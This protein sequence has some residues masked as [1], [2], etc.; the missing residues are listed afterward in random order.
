MLQERRDLVTPIT[1]QL[2]DVV[3]R[4]IAQPN[5]DHLRRRP[6]ENAHS[7]KVLVLADENQ[8]VILRMLPNRKIGSSEQPHVADMFRPG[9]NIGNCHDEPRRQIFVEKEFENRLSQ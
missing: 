8:S 2:D 5:P 7:V 3:G 4:A 6:E 9:I 1:Q